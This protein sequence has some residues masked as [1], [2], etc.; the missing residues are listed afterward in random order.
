MRLGR[1]EIEPLSEGHFI[2][3][4]DGRMEKSV[5]NTSEP[6][7]PLASRSLV[8]GIEPVLL[9]DD[10]H[11]VL[12]DAGLG[13]GLDAGSPAP[14][15]SNLKTNLE[16]FGLTPQDVTHV[17][18]SHLH[19]DH[20]A[21]LSFTD[22]GGSTISTLPNARILVQ[23]REWD[24]ALTQFDRP[25]PYQDA[26]YALDDLLRLKASGQLEGIRQDSLEVIPGVSL[27][28]TG[29]HT[30]GHQIVRISDSGKTGYFMGDLLPS[31]E[32][33]QPR[34]RHR[35]D[36]DALVAARIKRLMLRQIYHENAYILMYH[37]LFSRVGR[38]ARHPMGSFGLN[39]D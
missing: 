13:M 37:S 33:F 27:V 3:H 12:L 1:F 6:D 18:L 35:M 21:G 2:I 23:Q 36:T 38:L 10:H 25:N 4:D 34:V 39:D 30:P 14:G 9:M 26:G 28:F 15:V 11:V 20:A 7:E 22:R 17:V 5:W 24:H 16:I 32:F 8:V 31:E 29:G 19:M